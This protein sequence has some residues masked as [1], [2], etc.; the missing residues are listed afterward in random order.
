MRRAKVYIPLALLFVAVVAFAAR[1]ELVSLICAPAE[2]PLWFY[3][4][5]E[6]VAGSQEPAPPRVTPEYAGFDLESLNAAAEYAGEHDSRALIVWR[7][8]HIAFEKYWGGSH[9]DTVVDTGEFNDT[10]IGLSFG[11]AQSERKIGPG[12]TLPP[13]PRQARQ[14]LERATGQGYAQ[15]LSEQLWKRI[16]AADAHLSPRGPGLLARQGD[17]IRVGELL[18]NDGAYETEQIVPRG[19]IAR[20]LADARGTHLQPGEPYDAARSGAGEPY[21]TRDVFFL[22]GF[23]KN[24]LWIVPSLGIVVLRTGGNR[25]GD[26]WDDARIPNLVIRGAADYKPAGSGPTNLKSLVPNH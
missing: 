1:R 12:E 7:Q 13:E 4:P 25:D 6:L 22:A 9:F 18:V 20:M 2:R 3:E 14:V 15:Y 5:T 17:W 21:A 24:R 23:G 26:D 16:G 19:W 11:I 10:L 8:G